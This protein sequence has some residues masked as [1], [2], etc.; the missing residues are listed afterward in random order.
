MLFRNYRQIRIDLL[1]QYHKIKREYVRSHLL[2]RPYRS[3]IPFEVSLI[4]RIMVY[5]IK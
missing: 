1:S 5:A 3:E 2:T 4:S